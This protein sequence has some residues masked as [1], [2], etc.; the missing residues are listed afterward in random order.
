MANIARC[1][2]LVSVVSPALLLAM[3][4][5]CAANEAP[6]TGSLAPSMIEGRCVTVLCDADMTATSLFDGQLPGSRPGSAKDTLTTVT[7]PISDA[8]D[9]AA[10][11][12]TTT[13]GQ[14]PVSNAAVGCSAA[15]AVSADG[16]RAFVVESFKG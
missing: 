10:G 8:P 13:V 16:Q 2:S 11:R 15:L 1:S 9:A 3:L 14:A 7:L 4:A 6:A 12:W 5:G